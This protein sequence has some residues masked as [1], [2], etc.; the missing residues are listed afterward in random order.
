MI[1]LRS[2]K[3]ETFRVVQI[4]GK[5]TNTRVEP[6]AGDPQEPAFRV[7]QRIAEAGVRNETLSFTV[8]DERGKD[9][10]VEYKMLYYGTEAK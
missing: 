6:I 4:P 2:R 3:G 10:V 9:H 5:S 8:R 7:V 1:H